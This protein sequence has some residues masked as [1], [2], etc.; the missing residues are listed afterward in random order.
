VAI[1]KAFLNGIVGVQKGTTHEIFLRDFVEGYAR[2]TTYE[3]QTDLD[4]DVA[5]GRL[6][7]MLVSMSYAVPLTKGAEKRGMRIVGPRISGG[8]FGEGIGAAF[9]KRDQKLAESFSRA[10][11]DRIADGTIRDLSMRWFGFDISAKP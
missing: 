2:I 4:A 1:R 8:P 10:I 3:S 11:A 5:R 6:A 9:R 7:G